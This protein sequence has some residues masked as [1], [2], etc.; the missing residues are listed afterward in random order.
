MLRDFAWNA[1]EMTGNIDSYMF[2]REIREKDKAAQ[3][4]IIAQEETATSK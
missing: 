1:F 4:R 2:Y 3:E